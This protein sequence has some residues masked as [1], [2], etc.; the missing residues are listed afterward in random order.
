MKIACIGNTVY[1]CVVVGDDF[2]EEGFRNSFVDAVFNVGGPASNAAS[3]IA[4]FGAEVDFYGQIGNDGIGSFVQEIIKK[5]NLNISN[6]KISDKI[7][8][9]LS[10]VI[11]NKMKSTR[12]ICTVR[13]K[14]DFKGAKIEN[15]DFRSDYGMILTD[16]KYVE[17][18]L[19]LMDK[20]PN[21]ITIID[22][23]RVNEEMIEL[24]KKMDYIICS[25]DFVCGVTNIRLDGNQ[26][27]DELAYRVMRKNFKNAKEIAITVGKRGYIC[28]K[29]G[30]VVNFPVYNSGLEVVDTNCA[31]DIFHGA[32]AYA[33]SVG[34]TYH[35]SLEFAN[36]T[37]TLSTAKV[38]GRD[39]CPDLETVESAITSQ[40][41]LVKTRRYKA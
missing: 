33:M 13:S 41:V 22:A 21:A 18:T 35:E 8:T 38:G 26:Y 25:E 10:F 11:I 17:D 36:V 30:N 6:L 29:D 40:K 19:T 39:S 28:E 2:I 5:E 20:N 3:V 1:D 4:K 34:Y 27:T 15:P 9:P 24:C 23:G 14:S 12:T 37:A 16:G 7:M 31:G 32:F